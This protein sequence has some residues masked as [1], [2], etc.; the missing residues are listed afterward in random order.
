MMS[1]WRLRAAT[2]RRSKPFSSGVYVNVL[3][4]E[5][6]AGVRRA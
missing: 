4:D 2:A 1:G 5:G 3:S 6:E